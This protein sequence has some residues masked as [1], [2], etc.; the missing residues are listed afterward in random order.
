VTVPT[1]ASAASGGGAGVTQFTVPV[2]VGDTAAARR[3]G[4]A[5]L[6]LADAVD[7]AGSQ[8]GLI[9]AQLT[10]SWRGVGSMGSTAPVEKIRHDS[11]ALSAVLRTAGHDLIDYGNALEKAHEHHGFSLHKLIAVGA[12]VVISAAAI[13]VTVGAAAVV[14][15]GAATAIVAGATEAAADATA[16][17]IAVSEGVAAAM[18]RVASLRPLLT[19]VVPRLTIAEWSAGSVAGYDEATIGRLNWR[20]IGVAAGLGFFASAVTDA[21]DTKLAATEWY[22]GSSP[23][24]QHGTNAVVEGTIWTGVAGLDD[25][26]VEGHFDKV[27]LLE[28][29][30]ITGGGSAAHDLLKDS[31]LFFQKPDYRRAALIAELHQPGRIADAQIAH[32]LALLRQPLD[33]V[34]RGDVDLALHEGPGHTISR[35]VGRTTNELMARIRRERLPRASTYWNEQV[36]QKAIGEA[37]LS[38]GDEIKTWLESGTQR[39]FKFRHLGNDDVGYTISK[40][41]RIT[42][43]RRVVV[44][45][46]NVNGHVQLITS[47]PDPRP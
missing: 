21:V 19:F 6:D 28:A 41:G 23:A 3:L 30:L 20:D 35:H 27:D 45:L 46:E 16:A 11:A 5:Y 12:V 4:T 7:A 24:V 40:R 22:G 47:F 36:A 26:I 10:A 33:E 31:G 17:D 43:T 42:L 25:R 9:M 1:I 14:E 15:A 29:A 2:I 18:S 37:L 44:I 39:R 32:E 13:T 38:R 34:V 8:V